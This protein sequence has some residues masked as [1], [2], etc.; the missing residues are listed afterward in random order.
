MRGG[1]PVAAGAAVGPAVAREVDE[2][3]GQRR[4]CRCGG[5]RQAGS[6]EG[7]RPRG[8]GGQ[9]QSGRP[10]EKPWR[11]LLQ[12]RRTLK[13]GSEQLDKEEDEAAPFPSAS[14][15]SGMTALRAPS[16]PSSCYVSQV[17]ARP[18]CRRPSAAA[19]LHSIP[20]YID[21]RE[22]KWLA[23]TYVEL[24]SAH[25]RTEEVLV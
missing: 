15:F 16:A 25:G 10:R 22:E 19:G 6:E 7:G 21:P 3:V 2:L 14:S 20:E 1:R 18:K 5:S 17:V 8:D 12:L 13:L 24:F 9:T 23:N 4:R 11:N